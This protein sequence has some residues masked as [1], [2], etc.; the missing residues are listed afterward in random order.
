M[1]RKLFILCMAVILMASCVYAV[2][3]EEITNSLLPNLTHTND[4]LKKL[5]R[6]FFVT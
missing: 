2:S 5:S 4:R 6:S 1:S 3:A